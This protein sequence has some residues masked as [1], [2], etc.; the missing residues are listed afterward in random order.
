[1]LLYKGAPYCGGTIIDERHVLT[2]A[3][4][5]HPEDKLTVKPSELTV[6]VGN[7][8]LFDSSIEK[9]VANIFIHEQFDLASVTNDI[10]VIRVFFFQFFKLV[11]I[12]CFID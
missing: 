3:H 1:M 6:V 2:A 4:C 8:K 7:L 11:T 9:K 5:C 12:G 10:A